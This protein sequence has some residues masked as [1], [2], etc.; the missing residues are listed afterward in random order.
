MTETL[1]PVE[2]ATRGRVLKRGLIAAAVVGFLT[3]VVWAFTSD[4]VAESVSSVIT[5]ANLLVAGGIAF[6]AGLVSFA[7]PCV[8]PLVPGYLSYMTGLTGEEVA[9]GSAKQ[10]SRVLLGGTLFVLGFAVPFTIGGFAFGLLSF[11]QTNIWARIVMG[12]VVTILGLLMMSGRL[13]R[14]YRVS[15]EAPNR[16]IASAPLLGFVF[17]VGWTPC[18]GPAL[19]AILNLGLAVGGSPT[20]SAILAFIYALGIGLPFIL[21]GL[22]FNRAAGALDFLKRNSRRLQLV[23]GGLIVLT[24]IAIATG[25]WDA[26]ITALRPLIQ[27][28]EPPV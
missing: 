21:F 1:T 28:F 14:E 20:R 9:E 19:A 11:L 3:F 4:S 5:D 7:S 8:V 26:F 12:V 25:L 13:M 17:G 24:G 22:L 2:G 23:G 10:R 18:V 15:H 6:A 27:G 16:G